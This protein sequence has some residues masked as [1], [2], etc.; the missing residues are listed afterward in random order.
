MQFTAHTMWLYTKIVFILFSS[1]SLFRFFFALALHGT[2]SLPFIFHLY[3]FA[4]IAFFIDFFCFFIQV[5]S[6]IV[7]LVLCCIFNINRQTDQRRAEI[8][9]DVSL[10]FKIVG[11]TVNII[12]GVFFSIQ[13][14][15]FPAL[16]QVQS[17]CT[18]II[19]TRAH[20][21]YSDW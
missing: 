17:Q 8:L 10:A 6:A 20:F 12:I 14:D 11:I 21:P 19:S 1:K 4:L 9:N 16:T 2:I 7:A 15:N 5:I 13:I 18:F 3:I